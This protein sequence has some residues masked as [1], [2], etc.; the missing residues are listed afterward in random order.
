MAQLLRFFKRSSAQASHPSK[1]ALPYKRDFDRFPVEFQV[2][3]WCQDKDGKAVYDEAELHDVS[4]NGAMFMTLFPERY[5]EG[6]ALKLTIF[7]SGPR[8]VRAA[9]RTEGSVVRILHAKDGHKHAGRQKTG[10]AVHLN[11]PFEF[12]RMSGHLEEGI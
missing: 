6:Q 4:G 5:Y 11:K 12:E 9:I 7:L 10:I 1:G 3:V 8:D 2:G